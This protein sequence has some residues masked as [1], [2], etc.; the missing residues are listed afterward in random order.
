MSKMCSLCNE[1][2]SEYHLIGMPREG[3]KEKYIEWHSCI[4]CMPVFHRTTNTTQGSWYNS[5]VHCQSHTI[6]LCNYPQC[7]IFKDYR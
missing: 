4:G 2:D 1:E 5:L 6:T 3:D 7:N